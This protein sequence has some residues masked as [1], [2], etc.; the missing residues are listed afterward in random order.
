MR[1]NSV[2]SLSALRCFAELDALSQVEARSRCARPQ[3]CRHFDSKNMTEFFLLC[4]LNLAPRLNYFVCEY[5]SYT[6]HLK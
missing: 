5:V 6:L 3:P 2:A 4:V 1:D